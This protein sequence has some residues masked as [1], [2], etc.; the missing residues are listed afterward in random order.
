[1][2][3]FRAVTDRISVAPQIDTNDIDRAAEAGV[4]LI[5]CNRP[6][7]EE[8]GQPLTADL[9][10][11]AESKGIKWATIPIVSGQFTM[12]AVQATA[13]ALADVKGPILAYCRSGTRSCT[14]WGLAAALQDDLPTADIVNQAAAAGYDLSGMAPTLDHLRQLEK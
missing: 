9:A 6:D 2:T 8:M 4:E 13:A 1:M 12:E 7:G 14:L 3:D 10:A 11:Y 5:I